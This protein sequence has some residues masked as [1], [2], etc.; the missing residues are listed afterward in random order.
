MGAAGSRQKAS[1]K[2]ASNTKLAANCSSSSSKQQQQRT[3]A[4]A[5]AANS[6][7]SKQQQEETQAALGSIS[8][9]RAQQQLRAAAAAK[10]S[11][12]S[13][14]QPEQAAAAAAASSSSKELQA[15]PLQDSHF[16]WVQLIQW[17]CEDISGEAVF[18]WNLS[19]V[20]EEV[21][22]A[23]SD[24][25]TFLSLCQKQ[26]ELRDDEFTFDDDSIFVEWA[27]ALLKE[28]PALGRIRYALVPARL[29]EE[30]FWKRFFGFCRHTIQQHIL[31]SVETDEVPTPGAPGGPPLGR[32]PPGGG[33]F[34]RAGPFAPTG[35][36]QPYL[37]GPVPPSDSQLP[38]PAQFRGPPGQQPLGGGHQGGAFLQ[39]G[40]TEGRQGAPQGPLQGGPPAPGPYPGAPFSRD[41]QLLGRTRSA[42]G[43]PFRTMGGPP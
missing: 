2:E 43:A 9:T 24:P 42:E 36:G 21:L 30:V 26:T 16:P 27:L 4:A 15:R 10:S 38:T 22:L 6:N 39:Q 31:N 11:S 28:L 5:T 19:I 18:R 40:S 33:P 20:K 41:P 8:S 1:A 29:R 12:S 37:G 32:G 35:I 23:T 34:E 14:K 3:A 13:S 7:S 17:S 25:L